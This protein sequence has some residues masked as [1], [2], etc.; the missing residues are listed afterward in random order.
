LPFQ[1]AS[2][3]GPT[4]I[5]QPP[6]ISAS[7]EEPVLDI[8]PLLDDIAR[9]ARSDLPPREFYAGLLQRSVGALNAEGGAIWLRG[10]DG[11]FRLEA[12]INLAATGALATA[13]GRQ[14][15]ES[16]LSVVAVDGQPRLTPPGS[17]V[18]GQPP[19]V[20]PTNYVLAAAAVARDGLPVGVVELFLPPGGSAGTHQKYECLLR[21]LAQLAA[22]YEGRRE[23]VELRQQADLWGRFEQFAQRA[24][25]SLEVRATAYR[26][27]NEG[28]PVI[29]CDRLC[30]A[31][32]SGRRFKLTAVSGLERFDRRSLVIRHLQKLINRA[33][34]TG[35][36]LVYLG[37]DRDLPPQLSESL[38]KYLEAANVRQVVI[39]PLRQPSAAE[40]SDGRLIGLLVAERFDADPSPETLRQ[41]V[42]AVAGH[43]QAAL[44]N[45]MKYE[46]V[47]F[48]P[49]LRL[50]GWL[51]GPR[52][53]SYAALLLLALAAAIAAMVFVPADFT[54]EARGELQPRRR[55]DIFA[56]H[57]GIVSQV[58]VRHGQQVEAAGS[59]V[60]GD[61][62][63]RQESAPTTVDSHRGLLAIL[64]NT[65]LDYE[66]S[67]LEGEIR[68]AEKRLRTAGIQ[69]LQ[70]QNPRT[71]AEIHERDKLMAEVEELKKSVE[72][73]QK[74][75][76]ILR[77]QEREMSVFSPAAGQVVT[78]DVEQTLDRRPVR[79]GQ[80][81]MQ[82]ADLAGPWILELHLPD[83][84]AGHVLAAR[85]QAGA[86]LMVEF[87]LATDP[88][89]TFTGRIERVA[90]TTDNH[91]VHGPSVLV[92]VSL[93][94]RTK[95]QIA[96]LRPG[97]TVIGRI[98]C[99][100]RS[101]G[102]TW[103]HDLIDAVRTWVWF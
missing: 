94:E 57:D 41:R 86:P 95:Q 34:R 44:A 70:L 43:S 59:P 2:H 10:Q 83:R 19:A 47:P 4:S 88:E 49:L 102:Y 13:E 22:A 9:L 31:V 51:M 60:G 98:H 28:R 100:Q 66:L 52:R 54:I 62:R 82:I 85:R 46:S 96:S 99:G 27:A 23:L 56:P 25:G 20:N 73:L 18:P 91:E 55:Y 97:A 45:A 76:A 81:L 77:R 101:L 15:H 67:R 11:Q 16:L 71:D 21:E 69:I 7:V 5:S 58:L 8:Q 39:L 3:R 78:W 68:T 14:A 79:Q 64:T 37:D 74:Q 35:E 12:E 72:S 92:T 65:E 30:V 75:I 87:I 93:D 80:R 32:R 26:I 48:L 36:P 40:S 42:A 29:G 63:R 50:A 53:L 24:H 61:S 103:F 84:H 6:P 90:E 89:T 38:E 1:A 33:A 17:H